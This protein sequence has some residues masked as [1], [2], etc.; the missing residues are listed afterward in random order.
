ME[1]ATGENNIL[2]SICIPTFNREQLL[3]QAIESILSQVDQEIKNEMELVISDNYSSDDTGIVVERIRSKSKT[4]IRYFK[5]EKNVGFDGNVVLAVGRA[6]GQYIWILG[7]DDLLAPGA[8]KIVMQELRKSNRADLYYGEKEDF[9]LTPDRPMHFRNIMQANDKKVFDFRHKDVV[10]E[11]FRNNKK[12]IAYCNYISNI[13]FNRE[14]WNGIKGKEKYIGPGYI[15]VYVFQSM[16]WGDVPGVMQYLAVPL[17][18]RRWGNDGVVVPVMRL[19]QDVRMFRQIAVSVFSDQ[20]YIRAIDDL[21]IRNDGFSWA[22]R[23]KTKDRW[24]FYFK[25]FPFLW[26]YYWKRPLFWLK[27]VPLLFVPSCLLK[28]MRWSY[29]VFVKGEKL[30]PMNIFDAV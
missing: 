5:N 1:Q 2:L 3:K 9:Y 24:A 18:K 16:L 13:V 7:D 15:H 14:K 11:Y 23:A 4:P 8:L 25:V 29:R 20:K 17:I 12:L 21:V 19:E 28:L 22:V 30:S 27:I 26:G 6:I 10:D